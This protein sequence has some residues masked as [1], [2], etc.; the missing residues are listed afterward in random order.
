MILSWTARLRPP[1]HPLWPLTSTSLAAWLYLKTTASF[2]SLPFLLDAT[3]WSGGA[4]HAAHVSLSSPHFF[5]FLSYINMTSIQFSYYTTICTVYTDYCCM[6]VRAGAT[7]QTWTDSVWCSSSSTG[8]LCGQRLPQSPG[9][10][11]TYVMGSFQRINFTGI[12]CT[13]RFTEKTFRAKCEKKFVEMV[14]VRK[15]EDFHGRFPSNA[16]LCSH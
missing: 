4:L 7:W 2:H 1:L 10:Q 5:T 16:S 9:I 12:V 14:P 15:E 6:Y 13:K 11:I 8:L 3:L